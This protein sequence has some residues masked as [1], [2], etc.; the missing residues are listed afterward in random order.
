MFLARIGSGIYFGKKF[1]Y[2]SS[3]GNYALKSYIFR[4]FIPNPYYSQP[5]IYM[6][7]LSSEYIALLYRIY[8][9]KLELTLA[10]DQ[11]FFLSHLPN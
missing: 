4:I 3:K 9:D 11:V 1:V 6:S 8:F 2:S 5:Q 10:S 7:T